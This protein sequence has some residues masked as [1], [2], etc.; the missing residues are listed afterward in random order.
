MNKDKIGDIFAYI[1][2]AQIPVWCVLFA[3]ALSMDIK[4]YKAKMEPYIEI[5]VIFTLLVALTAGFLK[6]GTSETAGANNANKESSL[7]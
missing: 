2:V 4:D 6:T 1:A 5:W 7:S 3:I